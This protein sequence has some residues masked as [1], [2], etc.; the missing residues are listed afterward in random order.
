VPLLLSP[1]LMDSRIT[2]VVKVQT[3]IITNDAA[4]LTGQAA[5]LV[6]I[7]VE[8]FKTVGFSNIIMGL[9]LQ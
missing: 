7:Y 3:D 6:I 5:I 8:T 9:T 1:L 2:A 4:S